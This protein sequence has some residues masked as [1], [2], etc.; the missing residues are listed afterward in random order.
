MPIDSELL[1]QGISLANT[2]AGASDEELP[3]AVEDA[4][5]DGII[6]PDA[7]ECAVDVCMVM[8]RLITLGLNDYDQLPLTKAATSGV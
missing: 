6:G 2:V 1:A 8:G 5:F 3:D 7:N 4:I